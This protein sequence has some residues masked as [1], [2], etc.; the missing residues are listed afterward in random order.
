MYGYRISDI[1]FA[2]SLEGW[3]LDLENLGIEG[4]SGLWHTTDGGSAWS[5]QES[6]TSADLNSICFVDLPDA[7]N[8]RL[9]ITD[10]TGKE[11]Y[12]ISTAF[13]GKGMFEVDFH[14]YLPG[15]YFIRLHTDKGI[16]TEKI[17]VE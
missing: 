17:M 1:F 14:D 2:D 6:G 8:V 7:E 13:T 11:S 15:L 5:F 12:Q 9:S 3:A 4:T 10:I 16:F